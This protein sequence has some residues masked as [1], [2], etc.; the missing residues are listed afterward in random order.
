MTPRRLLQQK[1]KK[2]IVHMLSD[3]CDVCIVQCI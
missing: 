1:K 2:S 3:M